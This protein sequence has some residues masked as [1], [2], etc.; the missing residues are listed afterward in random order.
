[1]H[2]WYMSIYVQLDVVNE[3]LIWS[4]SVQSVPPG[5]WLPILDGGGAGTGLSPAPPTLGILYLLAV[6]TATKPAQQATP[7]N[8]ARSGEVDWAGAQLPGRSPR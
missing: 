5:A 1:M 4:T 8:S 2:K 3:T 7:W 6:R